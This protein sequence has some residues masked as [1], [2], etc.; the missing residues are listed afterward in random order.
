V[1]KYKEAI[2]S[3]TTNS[4]TFNCTYNASVIIFANDNFTD[5]TTARTEM[6]G[7]IIY[8]AQATPTYTL[9]NDTLQ[10]ELN[11]IEELLSYQGQ[12]NISQESNDLPFIISATTLKDIS[13]L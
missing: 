9:L 6:I 13:S 7:T 4:G 3:A 11:I 1:T 10:E 5:L 8:I 12:T 2:T